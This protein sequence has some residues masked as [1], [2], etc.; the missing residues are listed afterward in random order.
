VTRKLSFKDEL[1]REDRKVVFMKKHFLGKRMKIFLALLIFLNSFL[2]LSA[3]LP[4]SCD[5]PGELLSTD[6]NVKDFTKICTQLIHEDTGCKKLKPEK[7]MSCDRRDKNEVLSSAAL[8]EKAGQ[9]VKGFVVDSMVDLAKFIFELVRAMSQSNL[10]STAALI[11]FLVDPEFREHTIATTKTTASV[12]SKMGMAFLNSSSLY[13]ARELPRNL[14]NH[15]FNPLEAIGETLRA[16]LIKF[17]T[18]SVQTIAAYY[19]PQ[20]QCM[21]GVAKLQTIC[22]TL[23]SFLMPPVFMVTFLKSGFQG[24]RL[25]KEGSQALKVAQVERKFAAANEVREAVSVASKTKDA[26][27]V[28]PVSQIILR[29][30][31]PRGPSVAKPVTLPTLP[32]PIEEHSADEL[33]ALARSQKV[34]EKAVMSKDPLSRFLEYRQDPEY[35]SLFN[36]ERLYPQQH[37]DMAIVLRDMEKRHPEMGKSEIRKKVEGFMNSCSI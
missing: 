7:R 34:E 13:V 28:K 12:G 6:V 2:A 8:A 11:R 10:N 30:A 24:L 4:A 16:P 15:P 36:G 35:A 27:D 32:K 5:T 26:K 1:R 14:R 17:L 25:L 9:C 23:G 19:I 21:N 3:G 29:E 33:V 18:D 37:W 22:T 31:K 20:Y